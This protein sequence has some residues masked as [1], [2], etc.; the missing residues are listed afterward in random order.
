[1]VL[2]GEPRDATW[3]SW[4]ALQSS[5]LPPF[6][7]AVAL[8]YHEV[9]PGN[10]PPCLG[11]RIEHVVIISRTGRFNPTSAVPLALSHAPRTN[12]PYSVRYHAN[13]LGHV[14]FSSQRHFAM[15]SFSPCPLCFLETYPGKKRPRCVRGVLAMCA[16]CP[17]L[18]Y[19][20]HAPVDPARPSTRCGAENP[21][22]SAVRPSGC[23]MAG[24]PRPSPQSIQPSARSLARK[25]RG[26]PDPDPAAPNA[27]AHLGSHK[28]GEATT[29]KTVGYG[30]KRFFFFLGMLFWGGSDGVRGQLLFACPSNCFFLHGI[31]AP[32]DQ[33]Q[34]NGQGSGSRPSLVVIWAV[35]R[36]PHHTIRQP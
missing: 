5:C 3:C 6:S 20:T 18:N 9:C 8:G 31:I 19:L 22:F 34:R 35:W 36:C 32:P 1:M 13:H 28:H 33:G 14:A 26:G 12:M 16:F 17:K 29:P 27:D 23:A 25:R 2:V 21:G 24:S 15:F 7:R 10:N 30:I 4:C 11:R